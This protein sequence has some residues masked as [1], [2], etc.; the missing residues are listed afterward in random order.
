MFPLSLS[1]NYHYHLFAIYISLSFHIL[2]T[3]VSAHLHDTMVDLEKNETKYAEECKKHLANMNTDSTWIKKISKM[4]KLLVELEMTRAKIEQVLSFSDKM[5]VNK[6]RSVD[7]DSKFEVKTLE[8]ESN[9]TKIENMLISDNSVTSEVNKYRDWIKD[10]IISTTTE[11][12]TEALKVLAPIISQK[13]ASLVEQWMEEP[14][15]AGG[16]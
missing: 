7:F 3:G 2:F 9:T 4:L 6:E 11:D 8:C 13:L 1:I 15:D 14:A 5:L 16:H 12:I 10:R